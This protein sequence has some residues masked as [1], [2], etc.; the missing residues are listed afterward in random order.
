MEKKNIKID[1]RNLFQ[2]IRTYLQSVR[3]REVLLFMFFVGL[4]FLFWVMQSLSEDMNTSYRIPIKYT[5]IPENVIITN[6]LPASLTVHLRDEGAVLLNYNLDGIPA[7]DIDF[8]QYQNGKGFFILTPE[9]IKDRIKK[10]LKN[11]TN[12][13]YLS[14]DTLAVYY[15][16]G[17]GKKVPLHITGTAATLPHCVLSGRITADIDSV[18]IYAPESLLNSIKVVETDTFAVKDL[19]ATWQQQVPLRRR[20]GVK[21][22]PEQVL[23]TIPVEELTTKSFTLPVGVDNLPADV[24]LLTFPASV[25]VDCL[26]PMSRFAD[27]TEADVQVAVDYECTSNAP[28]KLAVK[29]SYSMVEVLRIVPDSV[30]YILE[31]K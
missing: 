10:N 15:A 5:N 23:V 11:T 13:T 4:S 25:R 7:L 20:S 22:V 21:I 16:Q 1:I 31:H 26:I 18:Q 12:L 17:V 8:R 19:A 30:E 9:Q 6:E 24:A 29:T 14:I 27:V 28:Q 3:K 2:K